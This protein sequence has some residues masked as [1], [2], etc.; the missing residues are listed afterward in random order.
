MQ[1]MKDIA[2]ENKWEMFKRGSNKN[3][4]NRFGIQNCT[5]KNETIS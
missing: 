2:W 3:D 4:L 5:K 1:D